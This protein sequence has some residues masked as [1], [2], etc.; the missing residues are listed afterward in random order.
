ME[1]NDN[2]VTIYVGDKVVKVVKEEKIVKPGNYPKY[3]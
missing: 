1:N 3:Y 2:N